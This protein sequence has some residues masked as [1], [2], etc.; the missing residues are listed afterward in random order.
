MILNINGN[1]FGLVEMRFNWITSRNAFQLVETG[2]DWKR[3]PTA[4]YACIY[5]AFSRFD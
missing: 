2:F 1:G 5:V 3:V 4:T